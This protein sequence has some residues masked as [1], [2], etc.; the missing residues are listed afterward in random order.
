MTFRRWANT[1]SGSPRHPGRYRFQAGHPREYAGFGGSPWGSP[2]GPARLF[3]LQYLLLSNLAPPYF[4]S[5]FFI[6]SM[7]GAFMRL[8]SVRQDL[9][10]HSQTA[11]TR[12]YP[13]IAFY[14]IQDN[15]FGN[16]F[17]ARI[18]SI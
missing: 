13:Y 17:L 6:F 9:A 5:A 7:E 16:S 11:F 1:F 12:T 10:A 8:Q 4:L 14:F 15:G 2:R 18:L 3:F